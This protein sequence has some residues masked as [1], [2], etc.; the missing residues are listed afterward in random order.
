VTSF[1]NGVYEFDDFRLDPK[2]RVLRL[3]DEPVPL[4]PKAFEML[5]V[6][7]QSEGVLMTKE[8]LIKAVWAD[9]FVEESNLTQIVFVLRKALGETADRRYILTVQGKGYRFAADVKLVSGSGEGQSSV[10]S[11]PLS[12]GVGAGASEAIQPKANYPD[13]YSGHPLRR[14]SDRSANK[15]RWLYFAGAVAI[16]LLGVAAGTLRWSSARNTPQKT[17]GRVM[18]AVLP[19]QNLTG[20]A[21]QDYLS[22][23][24]TEEM[25]SRMGNLDP[26]HLGIIARTSVMHYKNSQTPLNQI[27]RE[28]GVQYVLE[29]S[30]RRDSDKVRITAQLVQMKDQTHVWARQYDRDLSS[31]LGL[32]SEIAR[33]IADEIQLTL[34]EPKQTTPSPQPSYSS[35]TSE[36]YDLYLRGRYFWN[37]RTIEGFHRAIENFQRSISK[38]PDNARAYAGLAD[39][40]TLLTSY[41]GAPPTELMPKARAA[42]LKALELDESLSEAHT[43]LALIV[44]NYDWDWQTAE[45]EYRRAIELNPNNATAHHWYAEYLTWLGRF[46]EAL[47]ESERARQLDPLSLVIAVDNGQILY[48]SRQY[49]LAL[50]KFRAVR[51]VDEN[52]YAGLMVGPYEQKGMFAAA[53]TELQTWPASRRNSPYYWSMLAYL[54]GR[55]GEPVQARRALAEL[56]K[57]NRHRPIDPAIVSWAYLGIGD[58]DHALSWLEKA[59]AQHSNAMT[60]LRVEPRYDILRSDPRFQNLMRRVGLTQ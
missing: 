36:A 46:D 56:E 35:Q 13:Q 25:I 47:R 2:Q 31:L 59:Y 11:S 26:Q 21:G 22:D 53:L 6:L 28:L 39:S 23:G 48:Y 50:A 49:D 29:G 37:Q 38:D 15:R 55:T 8:E 42:A 54:Y 20:D 27:G 5:L 40:Y 41:S 30:V 58:N 52:F 17:R 16:L 57:M 1:S 24:M 60:A 45:K 18:L 34:G 32:Q 4:T 12:V 33:E 51:E 44:E 3:R 10:V 14:S 19:F 43:S 9:S 7:V